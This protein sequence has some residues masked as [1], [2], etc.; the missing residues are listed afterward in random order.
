MP[1]WMVV[2][3]AACPFEEEKKSK[4]QMSGNQPKQKT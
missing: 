4:K 3:K 1:A 2:K